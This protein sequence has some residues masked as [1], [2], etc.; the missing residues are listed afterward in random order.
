MTDRK[1]VV[2]RGLF[3]VFPD[4][5]DDPAASGVRNLKASLDRVRQHR[6]SD[7]MAVQKYDIRRPESEGGGFEERFWSPVNSPVLGAD[8]ELTYII[9]RVEDVTEFIQLKQLGSERERATEELRVKAG[10]MEAEIYAR[11]QEVSEANRQLSHANAELARLNERMRELDQIK[12][13]FFSNVSHEFRTPL[14]LI[15]GPV[16]DGLVDAIEPLGPRQKARFEVA[17]DN[18]L[19]LLK[20]VNTLLDFSRLEA[21]RLQ[22]SYTPLDIAGFTA[23]L[24]GMFQSAARRAGIEL[25]IDCPC[26]SEAVW[27]DGDMWEKIVP[28]LVSN[29]LKFTPAGQV[30][31]RVREESAQ[32][33]LEVSDTG[34]GIAEEELPRIFERFHRVVQAAGRTHEGTGIGLALVR[35]LV[36]LHGGDVSVQSEV[37]RGTT[38]R[39][40]I[41]KGFAHLP[42]DAVSHTPTV[43]RRSAGAVAYA[44]EAARWVSSS[45]ETEGKS[46]TAAAHRD[47]GAH[48][49]VLIVDDN[50]DL[51]DYLSGLLAP[52]YDVLTAA[53]GLAALEIVR[54]HTP[55]IVVSDVM[56]PR[57]DGFGLVRELRADPST[58][59]LPVI[60]LS[61]R[62]GEEAAIQGLDAGSDDYLAKPFSARELLAR[63]RTH[64]ELARMRRAW[65]ADLKRVNREL[66]AANKELDA[67]ASSVAH[68]LRGPLRAVNGFSSIVVQEYGS[69]MPP[70][71][72]ELLEDVKTAGKRMELL[73]E[74]LLRFSRMSRQPLSKRS[75][76]VNAIV[77]EVLKKLTVEHADRDV[78]VRVGMLP[79]VTADYS[80]LEQVFTN[81]LSNA[82]KFTQRRE[83]ATIEVGCRCENDANVFF[84]RDNGAGFDMQCAAKLYGVFQRLHKQEEF[85]GTG[86]GLSLA[87]RIV[88]RHGGLIWAEAA[89]ERGATFY[90]SLPA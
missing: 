66:E 15:L 55:D 45:P 67:F 83:R 52:T 22:A 51:R 70:E 47:D 34:I 44:T 76:N 63:V 41:P 40:Q 20:L 7:T 21:G 68:D 53:D 13:Q 3:E 43:P 16:E 69:Q 8:G 6:V 84:V 85:A 17:H 33:V 71:A 90:F 60:L 48:A 75:V 18:A 78:D 5:P 89:V 74:D 29:A 4:N 86:V 23:Q 87:H 32:V 28:N 80:L 49:R 81:L 82:F 19:R 24:A 42:P 1:D 56:M 88:N 72:L 64:V 11:A 31:V 59:S 57:L 37:G 65:I 25:L 79:D 10:Q 35:E 62:A 9:H 36:E 27:V 54:G 46:E 39:V 58:A 30:T 26:L 14:T 2:G 50:A 38:F 77:K 73:I 61:A 12:T